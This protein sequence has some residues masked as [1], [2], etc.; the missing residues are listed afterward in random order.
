[1]LAVGAL[2]R[3]RLETVNAA[4]NANTA[5][6]L[7]HAEDGRYDVGHGRGLAL[8]GRSYILVAVGAGHV[9]RPEPVP[10]GLHVHH[11]SD[12]GCAGPDGRGRRTPLHLIG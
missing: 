4:R 3:G 1:V 12:D 6:Q 2:V 9:D 11:L 8:S 7:E 5:V 10:R